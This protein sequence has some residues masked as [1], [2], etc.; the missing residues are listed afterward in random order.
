MKITIDLDECPCSGLSPTYVY[1]SLYMEHWNK[2]QEIYHS[3]L[4]G[5]VIP[6]DLVAREL[7]AKKT[8]RSKNVKNLILT[9]ADAEACFELFKQF[10][11]VWSRNYLT[12]C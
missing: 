9:Y 12:N 11:D 8:G 4:W 1:R 3:P 10:A 6:C 7:Y 2:L 5:M